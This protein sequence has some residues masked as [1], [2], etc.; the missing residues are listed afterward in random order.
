MVVVVEE[1]EEE[2]EKEEEVLFTKFFFFL[3]LPVW[4]HTRSTAKAP[5][6]LVLCP[7]MTSEMGTKRSA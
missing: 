7:W 6:R 5:R 4:L 2:V 3:S 1:E